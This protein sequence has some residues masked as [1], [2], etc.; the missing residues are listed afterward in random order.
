M[1][2]IAYV[3]LTVKKGGENNVAEL[4]KKMEGVLDVAELYGEYDV[5]AKVKKESMED[6]QKFLIKNIRSIKE[7]E[8]TSTMIAVS[9]K[10]GDN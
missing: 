2:V 7:V 6:L 5:I 8:Q 3:F 1:S 4:L 9:E 10:H